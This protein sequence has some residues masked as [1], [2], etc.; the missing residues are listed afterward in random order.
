MGTEGQAYEEK[1]KG[2]MEILDTNENFRMIWTRPLKID[3][4]LCTFLSSSEGVDI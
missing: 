1:W 2:G 3:F 4:I